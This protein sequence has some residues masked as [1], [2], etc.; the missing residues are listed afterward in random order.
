MSTLVK[1]KKT[2]VVPFDWQVLSAREMWVPDADAIRALDSPTIIDG[3]LREGEVVS[4]I[5]GAKTY[6]T[7]IAIAMAN[8]VASESS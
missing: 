4:L 1:P 8:A 7:W 6:K 5:G 3:M 2:K